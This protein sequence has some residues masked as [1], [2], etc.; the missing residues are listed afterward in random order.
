MCIIY[1][2][3]P[4]EHNAALRRI[5]GFTPRSGVCMY[6]K[7][8]ICMRVTFAHTWIQMKGNLHTFHLK[9]TE[10]KNNISTY[11]YMAPKIYKNGKM[12]YYIYLPSG[13]IWRRSAAYRYIYVLRP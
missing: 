11:I 6:I 5:E 2:Y 13:H 7:T 8:R 12:L 4:P 9:K 10:L 1:I 3:L